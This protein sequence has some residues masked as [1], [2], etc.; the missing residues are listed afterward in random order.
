MESPIIN[1]YTDSIYQLVNQN[2]EYTVKKDN[3]SRYLDIE[4][5]VR[6]ILQNAG[7]H[8]NILNPQHLREI[9]SMA[10]DLPPD[11]SIRLK[12]DKSKNSDPLFKSN[13][14]VN[15]INRMPTTTTIHAIGVER[16][17]YNEK[18]VNVYIKIPP[19]SQNS[20]TEIQQ[21]T[22]FYY[23]AHIAIRNITD[24]RDELYTDLNTDIEF[25]IKGK[26]SKRLFSLE[27]EKEAL[28]G[29]N[30]M[31]TLK[32]EPYFQK[33]DTWAFYVS[34]PDKPKS[35]LKMNTFVTPYMGD[36]L[37]FSAV[38]KKKP[39]HL[40]FKKNLHS[41]CYCMAKALQVF[42]INYAHKDLKPENILANWKIV[43]GNPLLTSL[44]IADFDT[45][46]E[47]EAAPRNSGT[48]MYAAP[49][50]LLKVLPDLLP[51]L[52]EE[53]EGATRFPSSITEKDFV[54]DDLRARDM[55]GIGAVLH[56]LKYGKLPSIVTS[57]QELA[58]VYNLGIDVSDQ[59]EI[60][61]NKPDRI[62][63]A[64]LEESIDGILQQ[65]GNKIKKYSQ[66][67]EELKSEDWGKD[68]FASLIK[69]LL[70]PLPKA[71]LSSE[72]FIELVLNHC[73]PLRNK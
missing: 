4:C 14:E 70:N 17:G 53:E 54:T 37:Q 71:R 25:S 63:Q 38:K 30:I 35:A 55:W 43:D 5:I 42:H 6:T 72:R 29:L 50:F 57:L 44:A 10:S 46:H 67:A 69:A 56:L 9:Y 41:F 27:E 51:R 34:K 47:I 64:F 40:Y 33:M 66:Q 73:Q 24:T 12:V 65:I 62:G 16:D 20:Q 3:P 52:F 22:K 60:E 48:L 2:L 1:K 36:L 15:D 26:I 32:G 18:D 28:N 21:K 45:A 13:F 39:E 19:D 59:G 68:F 11:R 61:E 31:D 23:V 58:E 8:R 49:E 7:N